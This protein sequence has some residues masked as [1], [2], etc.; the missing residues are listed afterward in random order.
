MASPETKS[1]FIVPGIIVAVV[2]VAAVGWVGARFVWPAPGLVEVV[3]VAPIAQPAVPPAIVGQAVAPGLVQQVVPPAVGALAPVSAPSLPDRS[4]AIGGVAPGGVVPSKGPGEGPSFDIVRVGPQGSAVIAGRAAPGAEVIVRDGA[5]E[6]ARTRADRQGS[7]VAI[8]AAPL[9]AG[10]RELTLSSRDAGGA[11]VKGEG[12]VVLEVPR[13]SAAPV[14]PVVA[15]LVPN[16]G[17]PRVLQNTPAPVAGAA[18]TLDTVDYDDA[19]AIRF[20]G[21]AAAGGALRLYI[22]NG[23]A[24][25]ARADAAGRWTMTPS[26]AVAVGVHMVRVDHLGTDGRVLARVELPFQRVVV[27]ATEVAGGQVVVQPGQ[28]LWRL[29]RLAYGRGVQ[30]RV[31]YLAN[32]DQIRDPRLIY[33]GQTFA[34]PVR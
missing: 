20:T 32:R 7:F 3:A 33:P 30:Y 24:G 14:A 26:G 28:S 18:V 5:S 15:L 21:G 17:A 6:V 22:D 23:P 27:Q 31:I 2:T 25:D 29:A 11:E 34:V 4:G 1:A 10:G 12:T 8:P 19:G 16:A 13:V 9:A